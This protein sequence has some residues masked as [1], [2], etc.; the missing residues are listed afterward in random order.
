MKLHNPFG[1]EPDWTLITS[2]LILALT[3]LGVV[4][5]LSMSSPMLFVLTIVSLAAIR[6]IYAILKGR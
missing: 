5:F 3:L 1:F 4:V 2:V 6:F